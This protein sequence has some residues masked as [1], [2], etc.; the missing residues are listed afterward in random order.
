MDYNEEDEVH[1]DDNAI[2]DDENQVH[3]HEV[4]VSKDEN[5]EEV[6][7]RVRIEITME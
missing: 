4:A 1:D 7:L 6:E 2:D 3:D 5:N